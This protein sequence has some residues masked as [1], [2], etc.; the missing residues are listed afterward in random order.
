MFTDKGDS[1]YGP[2]SNMLHVWLVDNI[3]RDSVEVGWGVAAWV[4]LHL[5]SAVLHLLLQYDN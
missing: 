3:D 1:N 2:A 5:P 4:H